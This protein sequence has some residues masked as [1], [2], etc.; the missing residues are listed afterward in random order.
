MAYDWLSVARRIE[1]L[2]PQAR[3]GANYDD[4][5][6][7]QLVPWFNDVL[8]EL[9]LMQ[10]WSYEYVKTTFL[11]IA[12]TSLYTLPV[13]MTTIK[14]VYYVSSSSSPRFLE[15]FD[16]AELAKV[17][18]ENISTAETPGAPTKFSL[19]NRQ[20][21]LFPTPDLSGNDSGG[22]FLIYIEGYTTTAPIVEVSG[23]TTGASPTLSVPSTAYLTGQGIVSGAAVSVRGA[24]NL[25]IGSTAS[26]LVTTV[27]VVA[28]TGTTSTLATNAITAVTAGQTFFNSQPWVITWWPKLSEFG[29]L[30]EVASYLQDA[31]GYQTWE[32]RY[33]HEIELLRAQETDRAMTNEI[34]MA[35]HVGQHDSELRRSDDTLGYDYR[36]GS[37]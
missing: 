3:G 15:K 5:L 2:Y 10:R 34:F 36:S 20:L 18:G 31:N 27:S 19:V 14:T 32:A 1:S 17:Y 13:G 25:Q 22:N 4:V 24:G 21:E 6:R 11:T 37:G 30:R 16:R 23:T 33:Q 35:A 26:D 12:G 7:A 8:I 29:V 9:D 28:A